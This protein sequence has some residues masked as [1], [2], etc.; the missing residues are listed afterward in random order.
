MHQK[1]IN[2]KM[3]VAAKVNVMN[4]PNVMPPSILAI[5]AGFSGNSFGLV[6][7][8]MVNN[9]MVVPVLIEIQPQKGAVIHFNAIYKYVIEPIIKAFNVQFM[10]ADRWQS[11]S[12]LHRAQAELG[13]QAA[14][15]SAK[16]NDFNLMRSKLQDLDMQLPRIEKDI[17]DDVAVL[18]YPSAFK[19]Y[20]AAHL[21]FQCMT[22]KDAGRTVLKGDGYT[23][24][25]FRALVLL[26]SRLHD[27]KIKE[28]LDKMS[29]KKRVSGII[30]VVRG[31]SQQQASEYAIKPVAAVAMRRLSQ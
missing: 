19:K 3:F 2:S 15:Y 25:L 7:G 10:F 1:E 24:D 31:T 17:P 30:G 18:N 16:I 14:M 12:M 22:V 27:P 8:S 28:L 29:M 23:D 26:T 11:I 13:I 4:V 5:D 20:P 9:M 6:V 21:Y